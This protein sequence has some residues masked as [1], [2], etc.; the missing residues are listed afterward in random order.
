VETAARRSY[1]ALLCVLL[2][3]TLQGCSYEYHL[4]LTG[5]I[6]RGNDYR[7][8]V[9]ATVTLFSGT[10]EL[11]STTTDAEGRWS[12]KALLSEVEFELQPDNQGRRWLKSDVPHT[13]RVE[14]D[15][16]TFKC[17]IPRTS[18]PE[19]G[20]EISASMV[21]LVDA[22]FIKDEQVTDAPK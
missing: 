22:S 18:I 3:L 16:G 10:M 2:L 14:T 8:I 6:L 20:I 7:P 13:I 15:E 17:P 5:Q 11:C 19:D 1:P 12:L 9:G 21:V 4:T